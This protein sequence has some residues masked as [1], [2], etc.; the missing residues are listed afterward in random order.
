M[1]FCLL[2]VCSSTY[3]RPPKLILRYGESH[4]DKRNL[5]PKRELRRPLHTQP[6]TTLGTKHF[7]FTVLF[8][9]SPDKCADRFSWTASSW[10]AKLIWSTRIHKTIAFILLGIF[11]QF[12]WFLN[13]PIR[14]FHRPG[15]KN[16]A[17]GAP[18]WRW[19]NASYCSVIARIKRSKNTSI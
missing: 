11:S 14:W 3:P 7:I 16:I 19:Y 5:S 13:Y 12:I 6:M 17:K 18:R 1:Y 4:S 8:H 15:L 2:R 9:I 10:L